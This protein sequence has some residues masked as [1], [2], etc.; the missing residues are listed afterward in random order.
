M[1]HHHLPLVE[2]VMKE[3]TKRVI[4]SL[5]EGITFIICLVLF[6]YGAL[7]FDMVFL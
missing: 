1:A 3:E 6:V 4:I 2:E 5:V 7:I